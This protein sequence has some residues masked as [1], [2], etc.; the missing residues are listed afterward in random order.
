MISMS[1]ERE[2]LS[3]RKPPVSVRAARGGAFWGTVPPASPGLGCWAGCGAPGRG[4]AAAGGAVCWGTTTGG[5]CCAHSMHAAQDAARKPRIPLM[6]GV[7]RLLLFRRAASR[8]VF[9]LACPDLLFGLVQL[10]FLLDP[11]LLPKRADPLEADRIALLHG[12]GLLDYR[13]LLGVFRIFFP[14]RN[15]EGR[16]SIHPALA[17]FV[18]PTIQAWRD[19]DGVGWNRQRR[20]G[21]LGWLRC[22]L[23]GLRRRGRGGL[24]L[25]IGSQQQAPAQ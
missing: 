9:P 15:T 2:T 7:K 12:S 1:S 11:G 14:A 23:G 5:F 25:W 19:L 6:Q 13:L 4:C 24:S 3:S 17:V 21:V 8:A 22:R 18:G 20:R 10:G 16:P